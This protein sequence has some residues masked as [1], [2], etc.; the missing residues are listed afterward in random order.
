MKMLG[1]LTSSPVLLL[2]GPTPI[3]DQQK[4]SGKMPSSEN[5]L[6]IPYSL[7][8]GERE[9][10]GMERGGVEISRQR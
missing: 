5:R 3:K 4:G 7:L 9:G 6:C 10:G 2:L 8:F 1:S